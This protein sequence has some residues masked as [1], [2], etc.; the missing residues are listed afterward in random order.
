[1]WSVDTGNPLCCR[2]CRLGG[3]ASPPERDANRCSEILSEF[4]A[5]GVGGGGALRSDSN[6]ALMD[7]DRAERSSEAEGVEA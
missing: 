5:S 1:M 4:A 3:A 7:P 2:K 6:L